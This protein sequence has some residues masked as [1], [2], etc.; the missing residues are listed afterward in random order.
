VV[1]RPMLL[2]IDDHSPHGDLSPLHCVFFNQVLIPDK[3]L[4]NRTTIVHD[5]PSGLSA[6]KYYHV[7]L[8]MHELFY[9]IWSK[10]FLKKVRNAHQISPSTIDFIGAD[11]ER[12]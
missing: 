4:I 8:D 10:A 3:Y 12:G 9:K 6:I 5:M 2:A 7:E 11:Q 1:R